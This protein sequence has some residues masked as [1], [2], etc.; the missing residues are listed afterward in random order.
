MSLLYGPNT[1]KL[2]NGA[3][4]KTL[5]NYTNTSV[6]LTMYVTIYSGVQPTAAEVAASWSTYNSAANNYLLTFNSNTKWG[7]PGNSHIQL[8]EFPIAQLPMRDGTASWAIIWNESVTPVQLGSTTLP[9]AMFMVVPVSDAA[10]N[11]VIRVASTAFTTVAAVSISDA[12][13]NAIF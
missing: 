8:V 5:G 4:F 11:G 6:N 7:M 1:V 12:S 13:L 3:I 2:F 10:G 9:K